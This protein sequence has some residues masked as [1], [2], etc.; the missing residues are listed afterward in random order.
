V[1]SVPASESILP[2]ASQDYRLLKVLNSM[3]KL[4]T[5]DLNIPKY[6]AEDFANVF[7]EADLHLPNIKTLIVAQHNDFIV[8]HCPNVETITSNGYSFLNPMRIRRRTPES[9]VSTDNLITSAGQAKSLSYFEMS[10][11]W[12]VGQLEGQFFRA[13]QL[14]FWRV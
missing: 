5:I 11:F 1:S 6:H 3:K 4:E 13:D 7:D 12:R 10:Q 14:F 2:P 8:R 9:P